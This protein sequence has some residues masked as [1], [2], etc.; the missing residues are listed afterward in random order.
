MD[1]GAYF[2]ALESS[3]NFY[4][5][6]I[7]SINGDECEIVRRRE[8]FSDLIERDNYNSKFFRKEKSHE[9]YSN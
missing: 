1:T 2:N 5:P 6:A 3:F 8:T 9:V 7:V 4:K